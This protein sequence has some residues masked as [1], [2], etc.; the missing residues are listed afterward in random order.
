MGNGSAPVEL[1]PLP[2]AIGLFSSYIARQSET[3]IL[4]EKLSI[5]GDS[6]SVKT[7]DGRDVLQVKGEHLS[8]SGRKT[9]T[10]T[11]GTVLFQLRKQT[12]SIPKTF[13][14]EDPQGKRIFDVQCKFSSE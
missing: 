3:L 14:C 13:Y 9:I 12:F 10:G 8:L 11:D 6:F 2:E 7:V 4:K 5:G 1:A